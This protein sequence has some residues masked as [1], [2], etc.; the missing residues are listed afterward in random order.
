MLGLAFAARAAEP[1]ADWAVAVVRHPLDQKCK[2]ALETYG[3][4][5]RPAETSLIDRPLD[6]VVDRLR[7]VVR[8]THLSSWLQELERRYVDLGESECLVSR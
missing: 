1:Y 2:R 3:Q 6:A 4:C 5:L 8:G 7:S